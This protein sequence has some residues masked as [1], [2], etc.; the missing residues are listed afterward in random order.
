MSD[1]AAAV[2]PVD[3][4]R[5]SR[6]SIL[7][8]VARTIS[9]FVTNLPAM[10]PAAYGLFSIDSLLNLVL[11]ITGA[12]SVVVGYAV[13]RF[14]GFSYCV[15]DDEILVREGVLFRKQLN[16]AITRVQNVA[17]AHPFYFRPL[18]LVTIKVE[19]A[20]S[21][22]EEVYL[23]ALRVPAANTLREE[24][25][26]KRALLVARH[27][28]A[29]DQHPPGT[30]EPLITRSLVDLVLHGLTNNRA[31]IIL[32]GI[33][34]LY[35][36]SADYVHGLLDRYGIDVAGLV[37]D[38]S[39]VVLMMLL[40]SAFFLSV[41]IVALLSVFGS[42][43]SYYGYAL[44]GHE[45]SF[46]LRRGL[47][48]RHEVHMEKSRIQSMV[49]REDWL[50]RVLGRLNL[51]F[52]QIWDQLGKEKVLVPTITMDQAHELCQSVMPVPQVRGMTY[53]RASPR[54]LVKV[55]GL[56]SLVYIGIFA[57]MLAQDYQFGLLW[58]V[59]VWAIHQV[60]LL[61]LWR[62]RGVALAQ[63]VLVLRQGF[64]GTD[65]ILV[66]V[67]K[68]QVARYVQSVFMRRHDLASIQLFVAS[69][70]IVMPYLPGEVAR[71]VVNT[72]LWR[73]ESDAR[74]WM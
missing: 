19:G 29:D 31:W 25:L 14:R 23:S 15:T 61:R 5:L 7:H 59:I 68:L 27:G 70:S 73:A 1:T 47:L 72:V 13:L 64:I 50:D 71:H 45:T 53:I 6:W 42:I 67:R 54:H 24:L 34:A 10:V 56:W 57:A 62:R 60:A 74:S 66:P 48:T 35:G 20:G 28:T 55:G 38:Q 51:V 26:A 36:Q 63:E 40:V 52:E 32:G 17:F 46:T 9:T 11:V 43:F 2:V 37:D 41:V 69:R 18:G 49:F 58:P 33:G 44:Y 3:W 8:F 22:G 39:L 30:D 4:V 21:S 12:V 16:L 65:Y